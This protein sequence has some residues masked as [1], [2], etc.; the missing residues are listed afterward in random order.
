MVVM[1]ASNELY[2]SILRGWRPTLDDGTME[3]GVV[4]FYTGHTTNTSGGKTMMKGGGRQGGMCA[5]D[6]SFI[7]TGF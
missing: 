1:P 4:S 7:R 3:R 5:H 6:H 2:I